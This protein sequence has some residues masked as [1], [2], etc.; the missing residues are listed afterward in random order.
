MPL[1]AVDPAGWGWSVRQPGDL[2][3]GEEGILVPHLPDEAWLRPL[4]AQTLAAGNGD[5]VL[6]ALLR[7]QALEQALGGTTADGRGRRLRRAGGGVGGGRVG[8]LGAELG[9]HGVWLRVVRVVV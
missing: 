5:G 6:L 2:G 4:V 3:R 9:V 8:A 7:R 1:G